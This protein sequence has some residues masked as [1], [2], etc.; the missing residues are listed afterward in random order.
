VPTL[1]PHLLPHISSP[2]IY[3]FVTTF[4]VFHIQPEDGY[5]L[6]PKHIVVLYVINNIIYL[7]TI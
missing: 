5:Y 3:M 6:A 2:Y 4:Y 1:P 7:S